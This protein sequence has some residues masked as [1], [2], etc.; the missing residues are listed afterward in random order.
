MKTIVHWCTATPYRRMVM[1]IVGDPKKGLDVIARELK[2]PKG[3]LD[4]PLRLFTEDMFDNPAYKFTRTG[5]CS[6]RGGN[7]IVW[8]PRFPEVSTLAHE[9]LH[10]VQAVMESA[11]VKDGSGEAEAYLF[12]DLLSY[13]G[14][15]FAKDVKRHVKVPWRM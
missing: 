4:A 14:N 11:G 5:R 6:S 13:F 2:L 1:T 10:A 15:L 9:L 8:F 7:S 12:T 3:D